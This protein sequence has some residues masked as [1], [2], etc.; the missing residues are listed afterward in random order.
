MINE[1]NIGDLIY[2]GTKNLT[3]IKIGLDVIELPF[4]SYRLVLHITDKLTKKNSND[5]RRNYFYFILIIM[6][7]TEIQVG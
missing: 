1:F 7:C 5:I 2:V 6:S 3:M 4:F